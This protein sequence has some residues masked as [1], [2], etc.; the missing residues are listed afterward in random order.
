[1]AIFNNIRRLFA[2]MVN[3]QK[4]SASTEFALTFPIYLATVLF[5][6][7]VGRIAFTQG[8]IIHAAEEAGRYALVH[9]DATE[10]EIQTLAQNNLL[11]LDPDNLTAI[12]VTAPVDPADQT[13]LV[14]VEVRYQYTPI[15]PIGALLPGDDVSGINL[16]GSSRGFITE[17]IPGS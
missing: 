6:V 1:M 13:K 14:S 2:Q 5:L 11:G 12:I 10:A 15:L 16:V 3:D 7:E 9:Y 4:G 8:V 17:E